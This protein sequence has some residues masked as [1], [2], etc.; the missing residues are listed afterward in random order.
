MS[1]MFC[2]SIDNALF[3]SV[4]VIKIV[5]IGSNEV[6]NNPQENCDKKK[7]VREIFH[8]LSLAV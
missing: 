8:E 1:D 2:M 7:S 3:T 6:N 4:L 5:Q